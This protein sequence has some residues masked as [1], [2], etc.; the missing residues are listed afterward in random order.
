MKMT[1]FYTSDIAEFTRGPAADRE[2]ARSLVETAPWSSQEVADELLLHVQM[3]RFYMVAPGQPT[4]SVS[5][6][7]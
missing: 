2:K 4:S 5:I 3:R 7:T 6:G 1:T